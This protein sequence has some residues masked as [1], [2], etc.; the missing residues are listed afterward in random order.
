MGKETRQQAPQYKAALYVFTMVL[1]HHDY[2]VPIT[3]VL[4]HHGIIVP[5]TAKN[6]FFTHPTFVIVPCNNYRTKNLL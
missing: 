2:I 3:M 6:P 1:S 5:L 4:S